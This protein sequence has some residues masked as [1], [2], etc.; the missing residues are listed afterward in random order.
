M[1]DIHVLYTITCTIFCTCKTWIYCIYGYGYKRGQTL[2]QESFLWFDLI[3]DQSIITESRSRST[4]VLSLMI[5]SLIEEAC[6]HEASDTKRYYAKMSRQLSSGDSSMHLKSR[7]VLK[8]EDVIWRHW[9]N[10]SWPKQLHQYDLEHVW[11]HLLIKSA[12][13]STFD[14][15]FSFEEKIGIILMPVAVLVA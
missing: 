10:F 4:D 14:T 12:I 2:K 1:E 11:S 15:Q 8:S 6:L 7:F 3:N 9:W 5:D 13:N